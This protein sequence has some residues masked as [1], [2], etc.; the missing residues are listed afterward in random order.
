M[1]ILNFEITF[2]TSLY[3]STKSCNFNPKPPTIKTHVCIGILGVFF[4]PNTHKRLIYKMMKQAQFWVYR[5]WGTIFLRERPLIIGLYFAIR[6]H[7]FLLSLKTTN[8][9]LLSLCTQVFF[10]SNKPKILVPNC[11]TKYN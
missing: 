3:F 10:F 6:N 5:G 11:K 2:L 7:K 9:P 8:V 4:A 1:V